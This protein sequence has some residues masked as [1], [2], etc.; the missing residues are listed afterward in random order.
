[1][2]VNYFVN[3]PPGLNRHD[4]RMASSNNAISNVR[5]VL[6]AVFI[7]LRLQYSRRLVE[8]N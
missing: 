7:G 1:M 4:S 6:S 2:A 3:P 8:G 5:F